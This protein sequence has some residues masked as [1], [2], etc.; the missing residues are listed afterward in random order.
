MPLSLAD[1]AFVT[2]VM[3]LAMTLP[4]GPAQLGV[5]QGGVAAGIILVAGRDMLAGPVACSRSAVCVS[6]ASITLV[7]IV[8]D[9]CSRALDL[10]LGRVPPPAGGE[11]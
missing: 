7:G 2:A 1:A 4:G 6:L 11:P 8:A 10:A 5:F 3:N 9:A